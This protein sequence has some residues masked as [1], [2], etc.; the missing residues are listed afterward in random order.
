MLTYS[1]LQLTDDGDYQYTL[2]IKCIGLKEPGLQFNEKI[3]SSRTPMPELAIKM[4]ESEWTWHIRGEAESFVQ[5]CLEAWDNLTMAG[6]P[7]LARPRMQESVDLIQRF[8]KYLY[9]DK[10][11]YL[12]PTCTYFSQMQQHFIYLLP[13]DHH[14]WYSELRTVIEELTTL[15]DVMQKHIDGIAPI[16]S[17]IQQK[18]TA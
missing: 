2:T 4:A 9:T 18:A 1:Q 17:V 10:G 15:K 7:L 16:I 5:K 13:P 14:T 3:I 6:A 8:I 12:Q 11:F